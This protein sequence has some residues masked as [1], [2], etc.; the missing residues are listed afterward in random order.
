MGILCSCTC[1]YYPI[2]GCCGSKGPKNGQSKIESP[3]WMTLLS[4]D[5]PNLALRKTVILG[6]HDSG[7]GSISENQFCSS[8][9]IC[10]RL[11]I[12]EQLMLG[13]RSF[14]IRLGSTGK[15]AH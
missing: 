8:L 2:I 11:S 10:T 14:D 12:Y 15:K 13:V 1:C 4:K 7:T 3:D 6:S 9:A 5:N